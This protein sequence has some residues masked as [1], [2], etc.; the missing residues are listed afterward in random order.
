MKATLQKW[1]NSQGIRIPKDL[2]DS[3]GI[4]VGAEISI[5]ISADRTSITLTPSGDR[6]PVRGRH[7]IGDLIAASS[8]DAFSGE[9]DWGESQ[10]K[11]TW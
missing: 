6:L 7:R 4:S 3:M 1:G 9:V 8:P 10:G 2:L 5:D 11:E